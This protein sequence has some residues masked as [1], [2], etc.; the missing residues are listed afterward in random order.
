[1]SCPPT[2]ASAIPPQPLPGDEIHLWFCEFSPGAGTRQAIQALLRQLLSAY[3]G[4]PVDDAALQLGAHGK[5]Y[6]RDGSLSFNLS[7]SG[8]A[9]LVALARYG[10]LGVDLERPGRRRHHLALAERYFCAAE[11]QAIAACEAEAREALFLQLWTAKEAVL[12][13]LGRGLA[14]GLDRLEFALDP[15]PPR[16]LHIDDSGGAVA[17]WQLQ[18]LA[19]PGGRVG[20][21]AWRG[22]P[23]QLRRFCHSLQPGQADVK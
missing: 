12:K 19:L 8:D 15:L 2:F 13:A 23:R 21:L 11:S 1:M 5:P 17:S 14:F 20:H 22:E 16:L 4:R 6:L 18:A 10:D 7:H 3:C 9:A